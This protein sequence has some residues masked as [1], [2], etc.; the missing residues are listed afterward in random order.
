MRALTAPQYRALV[1]RL[2]QRFDLALVDASE[3][4]D[5]VL[6]G[7]ETEAQLVAFLEDSE[8][9]QQGPQGLAA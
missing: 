2:R 9:S 3:L 5:G 7:E 4:A 6:F 1:R 8:K